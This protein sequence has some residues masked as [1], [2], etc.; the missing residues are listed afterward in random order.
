MESAAGYI[1][2]MHA[3][4]RSELAA[5]TKAE[6]VANFTSRAKHADQTQ[7]SLWN[8]AIEAGAPAATD[9]T[10]A[11]RYLSGYEMFADVMIDFSLARWTNTS[12]PLVPEEISAAR[13]RV[14][15]SGG[16]DSESEDKGDEKDALTKKNL[17]RVTKRPGVPKW[18]ITLNKVITKLWGEEEEPPEAARM[19]WKV[20][21]KLD[22]N[23]REHVNKR[24]KED[25]KRA[26][27]KAKKD[28]KK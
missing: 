19:I 16:R 15:G 8:L 21:I 10:V 25:K 26:K 23:G 6:I 22:V 7:D 17:R 9:Y 5:N 24:A 3:D 18:T 11:M 12:P 13:D 14:Q 20:I 2:D 1:G 27:K 4:F 28:K